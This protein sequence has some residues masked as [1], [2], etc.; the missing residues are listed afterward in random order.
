MIQGQGN[1]GT[2]AYLFRQITNIELLQDIG[3]LDRVPNF[4]E[5]LSRIRTG[6]FTKNDGATGMVLE[7]FCG[8]IDC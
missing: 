7:V 5:L 8:I 6:D 1:K 2:K 4:D 3:G